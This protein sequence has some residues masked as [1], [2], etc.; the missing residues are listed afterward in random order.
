[1]YSTCGILGFGA[2]VATHE[3]LEKTCKYFPVECPPVKQLPSA[4]C[5]PPTPCPSPT[6][7]PDC[8]SP[9]ITYSEKDWVK[10]LLQKDLGHIK[11]E[12]DCKA[13]DMEWVTRN[14]IK[15]TINHHEPEHEMSHGNKKQERNKMVKVQN[16]QSSFCTFKSTDNPTERAEQFVNLVCGTEFGKSL[17][18]CNILCKS[19]KSDFGLDLDVCK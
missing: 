4:S 5:P 1:M 3:E 7:C 18:H 15:G 9:T 19:M 14:P 11:T 6:A 8:P 10:I 12:S 16:H 13:L 2:K 17:D